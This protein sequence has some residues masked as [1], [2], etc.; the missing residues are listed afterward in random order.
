MITFEKISTV[1]IW[2]E[3]FRKLSDWYK[4]VLGFRVIEE[5]DHPQDTG[6]LFEVN[7]GGA[8]LWV[9][10]HSQV[11]GKSQ[12]PARHMINLNVASVSEAYKYLKSKNVQ[13]IAEPFKAF[14]FD[15]YFCTFADLDGNYIQLIG[16][17]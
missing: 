16:G 10:Q 12:D 17:K 14:T 9:G 4:E 8:W 3:D 7:P 13:I 2:S 15:K 1:L 11:H 6:V 5:Q